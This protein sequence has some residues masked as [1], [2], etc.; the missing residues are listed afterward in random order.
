[1]QVNPN[2]TIDHLAWLKRREE[3]RDATRKKREEKIP[4]LV[5]NSLMD[6]FVIGPGHR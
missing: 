3:K 5:I 1:M 2:Q 4:K 6:A